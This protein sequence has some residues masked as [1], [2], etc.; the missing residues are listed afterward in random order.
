MR[1][2][3][4]IK[5][6]VALQLRRQFQNA[7]R[8]RGLLSERM[9]RPCFSCTSVVDHVAP[10]TRRSER[11]IKRKIHVTMDQTCRE[12]VTTVRESENAEERQLVS[13]GH[14]SRLRHTFLEPVLEVGLTS[15]G[16]EN[17]GNN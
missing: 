8:M 1:Y 11:G 3:C 14:V 9:A 10:V 12:M 15:G 16:R 13:V 6:N 5:P 2:L 17:E 7:L 4:A